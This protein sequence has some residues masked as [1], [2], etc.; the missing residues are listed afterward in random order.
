M[1]EGPIAIPLLID[2]VN[3]WQ[4]GC[5]GR[6]AYLTAA[7]LPNVD[8]VWMRLDGGTEFDARW[9]PIRNRQ[10]RPLRLWLAFLPG[11]G[12]GTVKMLGPSRRPHEVADRPGGPRPRGA[13]QLRECSVPV[14]PRASWP[15]LRTLRSQVDAAILDR[16]QRSSS[17]EGSCTWT[18]NTRDGPR[19]DVRTVRTV[20]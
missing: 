5:L 20:S 13:V 8:R 15:F 14:V 2:P 16:R 7:T 3:I 11:S 9:M 6:G 12:R 18:R 17:L 10:G 1:I 19:C 4:I